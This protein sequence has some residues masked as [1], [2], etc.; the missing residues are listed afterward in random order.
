MLIAGYGAT[1]KQNKPSDRIF[2]YMANVLSDRSCHRA[3]S[4]QWKHIKPNV[5]GL[6]MCSKNMDRT[7]YTG[8]SGDPMTAMRGMRSIQY[9]IVTFGQKQ[10]RGPAPVIHTK[11]TRYPFNTNECGI[12]AP[13]GRIINGSAILRTQVPWMVTIVRRLRNGERYGCAGS[14]ITRNVILTAAHCFNSKGRVPVRIDVYYNGSRM[15]QGC[16]IGLMKLKTPLPEFD[17]FVRPVCLPRASEHAKSDSMLVAG[18]GFTSFKGPGSKTILYY[19][20]KV[21]T[22][23]ECRLALLVQYGIWWPK[24]LHWLCTK[25]PHSMAYSGDSGGAM[26]AYLENGRSTVFGIASFVSKN[27]NA[28][29]APAVFTKVS[30]FMKWITRCLTRI[31]QWEKVI[32]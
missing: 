3:I 32:Q 19:M 8:D 1:S 13:V 16:D 31:T 4:H 9:G 26:T 29:P 17:K 22:D 15:M 6:F 24:R 7:A 14:I 27:S 2:Y 30:D 12:S 25:N 21:L 5:M 18:V 20:T 23:E 28:G 10:N 11:A